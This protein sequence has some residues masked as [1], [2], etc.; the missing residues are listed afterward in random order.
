VKTGELEPASPET[1]DFEA[2]LRRAPLLDV[3]EAMRGASV[4]AIEA[5][6]RTHLSI[7]VQGEPDA[8]LLVMPGWRP[9]DRIG[10]KIANVFPGNGE[11][12]MPS[13]NAHY[14][15]FSGLTGRLEATL[16]GRALTLLRTAATSA[17]AADLL[18]P[19]NA[20]RLLLVGT[21][22][23]APFM[24]RAHGLVRSLSIS[25]W[26]RDYTKACALASKLAQVGL[27]VEPT[28]NLEAAVRQA[29][30]ITCATLSSE[31]LVRGDW[32]KPGAHLDLVGGF[33]PDMR[34][35]D[36]EAIRR[37]LVVVDTINAVN[38]SG[39]LSDPVRAGIL[40]PDRVLTLRQLLEGAGPTGGHQNTLFKSVG[41]A[42]ADLIAAEVAL[43]RR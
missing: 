37:S 19:R 10:I 24:A 1:L 40:N 33:R 7:R 29:D 39:D 16:D 9:G 20:R 23:L 8:T 2:V 26:G 4:G 11:R 38:E 42:Q 22:D 35:T 18:A 32:L 17:L 41:S 14:V 27:D 6:P 5:P 12:G 30:I 43:Q 36:D 28:R 13:V 25:V 31:P 3:I 34:E 21:G 15:V